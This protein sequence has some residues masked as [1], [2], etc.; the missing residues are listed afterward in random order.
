MYPTRE[1]NS[2][3]SRAPE[4]N[5]AER[6]AT[7]ACSRSY[8]CPQPRPCPSTT[9]R[10]RSTG[11]P[12]PSAA[13]TSKDELDS[14]QGH[15]EGGRSAQS[16]AKRPGQVGQPSR[17]LRTQRTLEG[18]KGCVFD[19]IQPPLKH[20]QLIG[21]AEGLYPQGPGGSCRQPRHGPEADDSG[22]YP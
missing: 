13:P 21:S 17:C 5:P 3:E 12:G 18:V 1:L 7:D 4:R 6:V 11:S 22:F 19:I 9:R 2:S 14:R 10:S 20:P 15:Q 16:A 8:E